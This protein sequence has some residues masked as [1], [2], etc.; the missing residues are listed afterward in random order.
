MSFYSLITTFRNVKTFLAQALCVN[1]PWFADVKRQHCVWTRKPCTV[2]LC[3]SFSCISQLNCWPVGAPATLVSCVPCN[4]SCPSKHRALVHAGP[5]FWD[6]EFLPILPRKHSPSHA[7]G[8]NQPYL[9]DSTGALKNLTSTAASHASHLSYQ[10]TLIDMIIYLVLIFPIRPYSPQEQKSWAMCSW[11][12]CREPAWWP[13]P[14][15]MVL[16]LPTLPISSS[17]NG[18][19]EC[20]GGKGC[21]GPARSGHRGIFTC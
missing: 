20:G 17:Q 7:P 12:A 10:F 9:P 8:G 18:V 19:T 1:K 2:S 16:V 21:A 13:L 15:F 4:T 6:S 5:G 11:G 14:V 3:P